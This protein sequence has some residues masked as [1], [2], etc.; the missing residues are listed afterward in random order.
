MTKEEATSHI[1]ETCGSGWINLVEILYDNKPENIEI[2]TVFQ[3]W[4]GLKV[5]YEGENE[6]FEELTDTIYD[7]SQRMCEVCGKSGGHT[8]VDGWETTL[9]DFHFKASDA[10]EKY[11][12]FHK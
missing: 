5:D 2:I 9:C 3:K 1:A 11:S 8:I 4:A 10:K 7:I 6:H 12:S